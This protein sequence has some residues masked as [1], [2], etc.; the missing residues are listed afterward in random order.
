MK[1]VLIHSRQTIEVWYESPNSQRFADCNIWL[2]KC[3]SMRSRPGLVEPDVCFRNLHNAQI[4]DNREQ[5]VEISTEHKG[6]SRNDP[7]ANVKRRTPV[8]QPHLMLLIPILIFLPFTALPLPQ[9][10]DL[11]RKL[12]PYLLGL[13]TL[14]HIV[15]KLV[16]LGLAIELAVVL[17]PFAIQLP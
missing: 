15:A 5:T 3:A 13:P 10:R 17:E 1:K 6:T 14:P 11:V 4:A 12:P 7:V 16:G 8:D 2:P 9:L